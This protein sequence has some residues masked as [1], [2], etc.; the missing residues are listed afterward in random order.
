MAAPE[1]QAE[2]WGDWLTASA[3]GRCDAWCPWRAARRSRC[4]WTG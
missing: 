3:A 2:S 4:S 1:A